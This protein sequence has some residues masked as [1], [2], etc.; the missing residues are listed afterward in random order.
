MFSPSVRF[1]THTPAKAA[2]ILQIFNET[3]NKLSPCRFSVLLSV[4]V[5]ARAAYRFAVCGRGGA[6]RRL[7]FVHLRSA[8][9]RV[10]A[11]G[12]GGVSVSGG[13]YGME[14]AVGLRTS[15][16]LAAFKFP[17]LSLTFPNAAV[18]SPA[19]SEHART[20]RIP[21]SAA[22]RSC[23]C[24]PQMHACA[25]WGWAALAYVGERYG[26][27]EAAGSNP[28]PNSKNKTHN[29]YGLHVSFL[30]GIAGF[31]PTNDGVKVRCLTAWLYPRV[32][33]AVAPRFV[34]S[35]TV[36]SCHKEKHS[37]QCQQFPENR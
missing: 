5:R 30:V 17:D 32:R 16:T 28:D 2:Q 29:P 25:R 7:P 18:L 26:M 1:L 27:E 15:P 8:D 23:I 4:S 9:A 24:V 35:I 14:K 11:V 12:V 31:E 36:R 21:R 19:F 22:F 13:R 20:S 37:S 6:S 34:K 33:G 3:H 10:R